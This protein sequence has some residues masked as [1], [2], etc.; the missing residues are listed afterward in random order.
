MESAIFI[1]ICQNLGQQFGDDVM[2]LV[3]FAEYDDVMFY[4]FAVVVVV[5]V[6]DSFVS[7]S[8]MRCCE[9][10]SYAFYT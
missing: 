7:M 4:V 8:L 9:Q 1:F 10:P 2:W 6:V 3:R 5:I